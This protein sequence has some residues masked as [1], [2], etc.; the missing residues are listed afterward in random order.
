VPHVRRSVRGPKKMGEAHH[1]VCEFD[2]RKKAIKTYHFGPRT[3]VNAS[4]YGLLL[5]WE[6]DNVTTIR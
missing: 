1:S 4:S 3:L 5:A 6:G 2:Q